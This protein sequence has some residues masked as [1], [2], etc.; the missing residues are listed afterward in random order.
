MNSP[1]FP[2]GTSWLRAALVAAPLFLTTWAL[3]AMTREG[4]EPR[5]HP[6]SLLSLGEG[7]WVQIANFVVTGLLLIAAAHGV[8]QVLQSGPGRTWAPRLLRAFG[9]GLVIAGVFVTDAGAGFPGGA[10]AGAPPELSWHGAL[11][12]L[13]FML[14]QFSWLGWCAVLARAFSA[15]GERLGAWACLGAAAAALIAAGW[16]DLET[17]SLRLVLATAIELVLIASV[18]ARLIRP[19]RAVR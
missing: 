7:G 1:S 9:A 2:A 16:P 6:M 5:R 17:L 4:F 11:H 14:T 8:C 18:A 13:G 10:P 3:Q 12:E 15:R 19:L